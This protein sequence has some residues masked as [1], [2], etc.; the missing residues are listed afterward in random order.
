MES[1]LKQLAKY[2]GWFEVVMDHGVRYE[3]YT[4]FF[5][6]FMVR[7]LLISRLLTLWC[8]GM[9]MHHSAIVDLGVNSESHQEGYELKVVTY[10]KC[11]INQGERCAEVRS[12]NFHIL[13]SLLSKMDGTTLICFLSSVLTLTCFYVLN[14]HW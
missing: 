9:W 3:E 2:Q 10:D 6:N 1:S 11:N 4:W 5:L 7:K 8:I 13:H 12:F 14:W